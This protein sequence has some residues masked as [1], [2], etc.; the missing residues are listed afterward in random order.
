MT[1]LIILT[2]FTRIIASCWTPLKP[3]WLRHVL[4]SFRERIKERSVPKTPRQRK[5][6]T[7]GEF[8]QGPAADGFISTL[9]ERGRQALQGRWV[10]GEVPRLSQKTPGIADTFRR[11]IKYERTASGTSA[12]LPSEQAR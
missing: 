2:L 12:I 10:G 1:P 3:S 8:T 9:A 7:A 4:T 11:S 5:N 6:S